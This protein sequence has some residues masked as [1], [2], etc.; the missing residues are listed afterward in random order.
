MNVII[1]DVVCE[2]NVLMVIVLCV[3]NGNLNVKFIIRKKVL[4]V[5]DCLGYCLNVVVCGL[6]SK[7]IIIVGVIIFDILNMFYVEL[8]CGIEDIVI[9][10]KY[11]IILSNFD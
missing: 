8:V 4:E 3:V 9:M 10:Y 7:K 5:I 1:Y 11:N 2:V 6:V